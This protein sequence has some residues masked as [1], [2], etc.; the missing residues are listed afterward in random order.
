MAHSLASLRRPARA[1]L[2]AA[3][4]CGAACS[5][6]PPA[7]YDA[8]TDGRPDTPADAPPD[9]PPAG[10]R[11]IDGLVAFWRFDEAAG[12][13][14]EDTRAQLVSNPPMQALPL[15][16]SDTAAVAWDSGGLRL[17]APV[18]AGTAG[19]AHVNRDVLATGEVTLEAWVSPAMLSQ[20]SGVLP[21]GLPNYALVLA[22]A[23]SYA[24]H[25]AMIA[26]VGDRWQ[27]RVLTSVTMPNALPVIETPAGA[28]T[29]TDPVH[30]ALVASAT[31]RVLYVNGVAHRATPPAAGVAPLNAPMP[32]QRWFDYFPISI[33]QERD[34]STQKRPWLGT[35][36]VAA[37]YNRALTETEIQ[38]NFAARH[39]C[40]SC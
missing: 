10:A 13:L 26:Q 9:E 24:Y 3:I 17:T 27:G 32:A 14:A 1:A 31:E 16:I 11:V 40:A 35:L 28:V 23:P 5:Y 19:P 4:A 39:D 33:G 37:I 6:S 22:V 12:D 15:T 2:A 38:R 29:G 34:T 8:P 18:R 20:G 36:W 7:A 30:L 25:N 21:G